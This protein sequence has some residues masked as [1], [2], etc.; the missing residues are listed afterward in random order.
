DE[1]FFHTDKFG[2]KISIIF[3]MY[4]WMYR[5]FCGPMALFC[6]STYLT[7]KIREKQVL[8]QNFIRF[9]FFCSHFSD[10][11][12]IFAFAIGKLTTQKSKNECKNKYLMAKIIVRN[13][14]KKH[15]YQRWC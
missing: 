1:I 4:G 6:K 13:Q 12:R 9:L 10:I 7:H 11:F 15:T 8:C 14:T 3:K 2:A 5:V